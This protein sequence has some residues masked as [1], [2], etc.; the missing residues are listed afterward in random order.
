MQRTIK[1]LITAGTIVA[2]AFGTAV[3]AD[4]SIVTSQASLI[5]GQLTIVGSGAVPNF[6]V[7]VDDGPVLEFPA[8][9]ATVTAG[10][11]V[12]FF[13][14]PLTGAAS[15]ELQVANSAS[16]T[17]PLV[18]DRTPKGN[19]VNTSTLP[20]GTLFWG[21]RAMDFVGPGDWSTTFQL[22]VASA[23]G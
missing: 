7:S 17:P 23:G 14:Q 20:V 4:A 6:N 2:V 5:N 12:S 3:A 1:T 9:G 16:F 19:Q 18:L 21:V 11:Q 8:N 15:Y 22:T 13:W 10:Q